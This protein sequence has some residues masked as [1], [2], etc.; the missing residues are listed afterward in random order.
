MWE[1][2]ESPGNRIVSRTTRGVQRNARLDS[3]EKGATEPTENAERTTDR[4]FLL[5]QP[6]WLQQ[7]SIPSDLSDFAGAV[8]E[9]I[10]L[11]TKSLQHA[12]EEI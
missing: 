7:Q 1:L 6:L 2:S 5:S 11:N 4:N 10:G 9:R 12:D 8:G 3:R